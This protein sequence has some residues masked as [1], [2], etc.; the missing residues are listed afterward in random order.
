MFLS[1]SVYSHLES[2][3]VD[4]KKGIIF[5]YELFDSDRV[6]LTMILKNGSQ[7]HT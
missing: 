7:T 1:A 6:T 5:L 4:T 2:A 3:P